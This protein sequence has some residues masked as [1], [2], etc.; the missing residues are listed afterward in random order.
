M[1]SSTLSYLTSLCPIKNNYEQQYL[2]G[3]VVCMKFGAMS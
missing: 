1:I 2:G 3:N